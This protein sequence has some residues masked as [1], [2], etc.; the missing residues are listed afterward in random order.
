VVGFLLT[1]VAGLEFIIGRCLTRACVFG[2][3]PHVLSDCSRADWD[4]VDVLQ[5]VLDVVVR[6]VVVDEVEDFLFT[7]LEI[8]PDA[9][10][11]HVSEFMGWS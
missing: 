4:A 9:A 10:W 6:F 1:S 7:R 5:P 11:S 2:P 8:D 3:L